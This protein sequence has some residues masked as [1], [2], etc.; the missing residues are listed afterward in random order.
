MPNPINNRGQNY[1]RKIPMYEIFNKKTGEKMGFF[2]NE[3]YA[4][5]I[6]TFLNEQIENSKKDNIEKAFM[7]PIE[8]FGNVK[9][10]PIFQELY[11]QNLI[12]AEKYLENMEWENW[13]TEPPDISIALKIAAGLITLEEALKNKKDEK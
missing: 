7:K 11:K 8:Y 1:E 10:E 12:D 5:T 6:E 3:S 2:F 9:N 4:K 13:T